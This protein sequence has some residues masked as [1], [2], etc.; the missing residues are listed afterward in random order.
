MC[1]ARNILLYTLIV[2][3]EDSLKL[4]NIYYHLFLDNESLELVHTQIQKLYPLSASMQGWHDSKYGRLLRICDQG[5]LLRIRRIWASYGGS[6]LSG[7]DEASYNK[8]FESGMKTARDMQTLH[9]GQGTNLTGFRSAAPISTPS[10]QDLPKLFQH[11]WQHGITGENP[12]SISKSRF[13]NPMFAGSLGDTFILHYG[14]DPLLG[15]HLATAYA[16]LTSGSPLESSGDVHLHKVVAAARLQFREW[17]ASFKKDAQKNLT[18]RFFAGEALAFCHTLQHMHATGDKSQSNWYRDQYHLEA[19]ILDG[20]D[21][22]PNGDAPLLFNVIDTSN[23]LDH[24][25]AINLLVAASPV[26]ESSTCATLYTEVL[27]KKQAD[28]K[29]LVDDMFCG[30]FPTL[31]VLFGLLL[32]EYWTS[33]TA[34]SNVEEHLLDSFTRRREHGESKAGQLH[35]RL[36]WKRFVAESTTLPFIHLDGPELAHILYQTYL[37]MFQNE[38]LTRLISKIDLQTIQNSSLLHYHRG[39]FAYFLRFIKQRVVVDWNES[40]DVFVGLLEDKSIS[41]MS[42]SCMQELYLQLHLFD[43]YTTPTFRHHFDHTSRSQALKGLSAWKEIPAVICITLKVPRA[44]LR[45]ITEV[46]SK[47]L[48]NP[49][50]QCILQSSGSHH[51]QEWQSKFAMVQ[52]AFGEATISGARCDDGFR[53]SVSEDVHAWNGHSSLLVSF[54]APSWMV[55]QE[56]QATTVAVGIQRTPQSSLTFMG[57]LGYDMSIFKTTLGN[58]ENVYITK[59]R[60]N[61]SGHASVC[62]FGKL[63]KVADNN[64]NAEVATTVKAS[65]D[66]KTGRI[67]ALIGRL[68]IFLESIK[69]CLRNGAP[70]ETVQVSPCTISIAVGETGPKFHLRFPVPVQQSRSKSRIARKSSYVEVIAPMADPRDGAG[71]PHFMYP[72]FPNKIGPVIWNMPRLNLDCLPILDTSKKKDLEWL[73]THTTLMFSSRE[74]HL[75]ERSTEPGAAKQE[76]VR[77]NFK[78]SLFSFFI[79]FSGLQGQQARF[80]GINHPGRG[81]VHILV[82]VSCLRLDLANHTAVLDAAILPLRNSLMS[83][84][85]PFLE[86]LRGKEMCN[87]TVDDDELRLFKE[88]IPAWVE[89]CRQWEHRPSCAYLSKSKIPLSLEFGEN[90]ICACGEG[91]F[92]SRDSFGL[93]KWGLASKYAVRAAISPSFSVPFIEQSFDVNE[94]TEPTARSETCCRGCGK[95]DSN[96]GGKG[97]LRCARCQAV[98]YC[99]VE[100]Q[101]ADWKAH[102]QVCKK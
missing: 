52:L 91:T 22:A 66:L 32:I 2:D 12:A 80:F 1:I 20:E 38:D 88:T 56:P 30:H 84:I 18:I 79:Q 61:L 68:D 28:L 82:F 67:G 34:V 65:V 40:M 46:P 42:K 4:W 47:N 35:S 99:S 92:P 41:S 64:S 90:P 72:I 6:H 27:V 89:R 94:L 39:S 55:M 23:L 69:S 7:D 9:L 76:D 53:V 57:S 78:D 17:C 19:L 100:C 45:A 33:S 98:R 26:L 44:Q 14:T 51:G 96:D 54:L 83:K 16:S 81:G 85:V 58:E 3:D 13:P 70:V 60:P 8:R 97:L 59:Y 101:R 75:R 102:K 87:I 86:E 77:T 63:S 5:T 73:T 31:S 24:V 15:F 29:A 36:T 25:G 11:F 43:L 50:L 10:L 95:A 48:G 93:R 37:K 74:R 62:D 49:I 71:F 21:Y